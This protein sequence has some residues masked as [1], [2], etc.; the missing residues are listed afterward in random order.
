[1]G[2]ALWLGSALVV[3]AAIRR[4]P[5]ARPQRRLG[6]LLTVLAA[7]AALGL[8]ATALDFGGWNEPDWR[9]AL[10]ALFGSA[11]VAGAARLWRIRSAPAPHSGPAAPSRTP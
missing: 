9:A 2:I 3:F 4:V 7:A 11:A 5:H 8:A 1:M 6:E 10:F